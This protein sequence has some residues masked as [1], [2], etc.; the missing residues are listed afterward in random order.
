MDSP[1]CRG[2][3]NIYAE[4]YFESKYK[5]QKK[6]VPIRRHYFDI[7]KWAD[8]QTEL[9][10][11]DGRGKSALDIGCAYGY[12][13]E[14]LR[15]LGYSAYGMDLSKF[16][17]TKGKRYGRDLI[18]GSGEFL[19]VGPSSFDLVTCFETLEHMHHPESM[20]AMIHTI[21]KSRGV[22]LFSTVNPY[23]IST[24]IQFLTRV[25]NSTHPSV[26]SVHGWIETLKAFKL[27]VEGFE[28][29]T[30]MPIP[31]LLFKKYFITK[32]P[33]HLSSHVRMLAIKPHC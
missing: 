21:L 16:A 19:P 4:W 1:A 10:L 30:L 28:T 13:V 26:R 18:L 12:V 32:A 15:D 14:L 9:K 22:F 29:F 31:P 24:I 17:L 20:L 5:Y 6:R 7:L 8:E 25:P 27:K 3:L 2:E 23:P 11:V 33:K